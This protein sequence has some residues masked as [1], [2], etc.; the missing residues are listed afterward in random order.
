MGTAMAERKTTSGYMH[1]F[2]PEEQDRLRRQARVVEPHVH[3]RVSFHR[4]RQLLDPH[5]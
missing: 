2:T 5:A 3:D 4:S 1:G